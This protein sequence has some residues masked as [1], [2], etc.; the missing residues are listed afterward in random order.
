MN[1]ASQ[2]KIEYYSIHGLILKKDETDLIFYDYR[3]DLLEDTKIR[4]GFA[5]VDIENDLLIIKNVIPEDLNE[6][7]S[8]KNFK[9]KLENLTSKEIIDLMIMIKSSKSKSIDYYEKDFAFTKSNIDFLPFWKETKKYM[10]VEN[11]FVFIFDCKTGN[12]IE[13]HKRQ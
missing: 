8:S 3:K 12:L 6:F 10:L 11:N 5:I 7:V 13:S 2:N 9:N 4:C 1:T